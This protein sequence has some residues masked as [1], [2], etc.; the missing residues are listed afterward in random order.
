MNVTQKIPITIE[1]FYKITKGRHKGEIRYCES[2]PSKRSWYSRDKRKH[3]TVTKII[4]APTDLP[5]LLQA[6]AKTI[7][8]SP[9]NTQF[10]FHQRGTG[11]CITAFGNN[12]RNGKPAVAI[13]EDIQ[14][15]FPL[16][17]QEDG[18]WINLPEEI[19]SLR[20]FNG[21]Q[22]ILDCFSDK[23]VLAAGWTWKRY[24]QST[25]SKVAAI[26]MKIQSSMMKCRQLTVA[27]A[28]AI[29]GLVSALIK[30][31]RAKAA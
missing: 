29:K 27:D 9:S 19:D 4:S 2:R 7:G 5:G 10:R 18:L 1:K 8:Q 11:V 23:T 31:S 25:R 14:S 15:P 22:E 12:E 20:S 3:H 30:R 24:R 13:C 21:S 16:R 17:K 6:V 26:A 28:K